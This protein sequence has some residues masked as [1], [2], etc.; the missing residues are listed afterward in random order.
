MEWPSHQAHIVGGVHFFKPMPE[1]I[2]PCSLSVSQS[3]L[4]CMEHDG[5]DDPYSP[6]LS[7]LAFSSH[8]A[9]IAA[10]FI[11]NPCAN[12]LAACF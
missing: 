1:F 12:V 10:L 6:L 11:L 2:P 8:L 9:N 7:F 3:T 5:T 4:A